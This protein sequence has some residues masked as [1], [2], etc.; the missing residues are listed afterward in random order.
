MSIAEMI[1]HVTYRPARRMGIWPHRGHVAV[2]SA[3]DLVVFDPA[4][5][6]DTATYEEPKRVAEGIKMVLVNGQVV[7]EEGITM[8]KQAGRVLRR[9]PGGGVQ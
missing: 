2:G 5:I 9:R 8:K 7:C 1:S 6:R 4:T 3:A